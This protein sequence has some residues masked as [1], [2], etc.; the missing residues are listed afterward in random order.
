M[1]S[2]PS[3][4]SSCEIKSLHEKGSV[5]RYSLADCTAS[6]FQF[7][8][9]LSTATVASLTEYPPPSGESSWSMRPCSEKASVP[10]YCLAS[11]TALCCCCVKAG[12]EGSVVVVV[13]AAV[14]V[15][16]VGATVAVVVVGAADV[17]VGAAVVVVGAAAGVDPHAASANMLAPATA[18]VRIRRWAWRI[19]ERS[20]T[21][22]LPFGSV[23]EASSLHPGRQPKWSSLPNGA[24]LLITGKRLYT[25]TVT[26]WP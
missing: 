15:V 23:R 17:V 21:M 10:R 12:F 1:N 4:E 6:V 3:G 8:V 24:S 22:T 13:G 25:L 20:G 9:R 7:T 2:P 19:V 26:R 14:V 16:V 5:W 18:I 11:A